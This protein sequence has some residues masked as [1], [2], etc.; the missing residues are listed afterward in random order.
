MPKTLS[1]TCKV[2]L[3]AAVYTAGSDPTYVS[4]QVSVDQVIDVLS[5]LEQNTMSFYVSSDYH[6]VT[7]DED[8]VSESYDIGFRK[9]V[10]ERLSSEFEIQGN[11][12]I[13]HSTLY[14]CVLDESDKKFPLNVNTNWF[15][16]STY[17]IED[18]WTGI[19]GL[20]SDTWIHVVEDTG[21]LKND[22]VDG[23]FNIMSVDVKGKDYDIASDAS[24][25]SFISS[26]G[27]DLC[28]VL[29]LSSDSPITPF[30]DGTGD[31]QLSSVKSDKY[32]RLFYP[33]DKSERV[34]QVTFSLLHYLGTPIC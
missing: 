2:C 22:Y 31:K 15:F 33:D 30:K 7:F 21:A 19:M 23:K 4:D 14:Y 17:Y 12:Y 24:S 26:D 6:D 18:E 29:K 28:A 13:D 20:S 9:G 32:V 5:A 10:A 8:I 3:S 25:F 11:D 1:S 16:L 34:G 27:T